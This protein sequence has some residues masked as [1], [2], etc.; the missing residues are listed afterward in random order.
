VDVDGM[1]EDELTTAVRT[2]IA[3]TIPELVEDAMS[4]IRVSQSMEIGDNSYN[5]LAIPDDITIDTEGMDISMKTQVMPETVWAE[6]WGSNPP[7]PSLG[8]FGYPTFAETSGG[9]ELALGIDF[10]NQLMYGVWGGGLLDTT[11]T[12]E[13]LGIDVALIGLVLP[14]LTD[15]TLVTTP[16]LPP[17][18]VPY[19]DAEAG[20]ELAMQLGDMYVQIYNGP[21]TEEA[22]YMELY[23]S[24]RIPLTLAASAEGDA[25]AIELAD[26]EV[27][28]DV[29][30]PDASSAAAAGA[31][32]AFAV[33]LPAFLPE[34]T[35]ALGEIPIPTL[36]GFG[37]EDIT[38]DLVGTDNGHLVIGGNLAIE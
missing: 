32:G 17:A 20:T 16:T 23:V 31:E 30:A 19:E 2:E 15:L 28:V 1:I 6:E 29:I 12:D 9:T 37:L 34:I 14:G 25:I 18:I 22:L 11:M 36:Y 38:T 33:L 21:E 10:F 3:G 27:W 24:A 13:S 35:G 8:D 26:P 4:G 7:G 5:I